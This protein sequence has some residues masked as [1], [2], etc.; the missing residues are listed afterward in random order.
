MT[1]PPIKSSGAGRVQGLCLPKTRETAYD[2]SGPVRGGD[3]VGLVGPSLAEQLCP[4]PGTPGAVW[5]RKLCW[6]GVQG[7]LALPT[8]PWNT[9]EA[10]LDSS[11]SYGSAVSMS[12]SL[13][14]EVEEHLGRERQAGEVQVLVSPTPHNPPPLISPG[15]QSPS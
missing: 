11:L 13:F 3:R 1:L 9:L 5:P 15:F 7:A 4:S 6:L 8:Q 12:R 10:E 2:C 14:L